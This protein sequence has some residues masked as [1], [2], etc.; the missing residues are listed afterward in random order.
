MPF[1]VLPK[2]GI[3]IKPVQLGE[4]FWIGCDDEA[5]RE[6]MNVP[7]FDPARYTPEPSFY[8]N[9]VYPILST[10][11]PPFRDQTPSGSW[12]GLIAYNTVD[13]LP[14]IFQNENLIVAGG[15][16]GSGIMK[17]D[18]LGRIV[19]SL[20]RLGPD[21]EASL[22]GNVSYRVSKLGIGKRSVELEEWVL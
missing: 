9:D 5:N 4:Q 16:S 10:Y 6:F 13:Y 19:Q 2:C 17:A 22:Y 3:Y 12:A 1:L 14:Y 21:S 11:L 18:S 7:D 8:Q 20:Y 15:D